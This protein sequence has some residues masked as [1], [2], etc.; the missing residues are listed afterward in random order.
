M[1]TSARPELGKMRL[2]KG[3]S[4]CFFFFSVFFL[5][6]STDVDFSECFFVVEGVCVFDRLCS[7]IIK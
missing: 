6:Y 2:K 4:R 5:S 1:W 3:I 7:V